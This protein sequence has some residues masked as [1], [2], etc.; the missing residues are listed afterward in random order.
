MDE[1]RENEEEE[2]SSVSE[3]TLMKRI[4]HDSDGLEEESD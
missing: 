4:L 2:E 1:Y 3:E